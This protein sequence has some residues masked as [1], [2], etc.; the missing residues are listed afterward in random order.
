MESLSDK[1]MNLIFTLMN[2]HIYKCPKLADSP[3]HIGLG[4]GRSYSISCTLHTPFVFGRVG[5]ALEPERSLLKEQRP[6]LISL[7]TWL[8]LMI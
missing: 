4:E 6:Y 8:H 5:K 7:T 2:M 1:L 3:L